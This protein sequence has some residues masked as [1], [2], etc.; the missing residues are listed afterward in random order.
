MKNGSRT[1]KNF[2]PPHTTAILYLLCLLLVS[3]EQ[4]CFKPPDDQLDGYHEL[5]IAK[6]LPIIRACKKSMGNYLEI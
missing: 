5:W 4:I 2:I 3:K 1:K 6:I